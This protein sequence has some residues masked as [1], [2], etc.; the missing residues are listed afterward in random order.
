[1]RQLQVVGSAAEIGGEGE[2]QHSGYGKKLMEEAEERAREE[3]RE[4]LAVISA[5]GTREYYRNLG[6]ERDGPYMSKRV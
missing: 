3:G 1:M 6:Y 5:V 2:F 4:K